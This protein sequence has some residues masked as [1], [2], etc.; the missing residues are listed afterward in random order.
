MHRCLIGFL[1][2][3]GV[4]GCQTEDPTNRDALRRTIDSVNTRIESWYAKGQVDSLVSVFA[5]DA[6]Q[7][8]PNR[9]PLVGRDSIRAFWAGAVRWGQWEF[10]FQTADVVAADSVAVE[11]GRYTLK[12]TAGAEAPLPSLQDRGNYV[13]YWRRERDG[14]WRIVWDAPVSVLPP[15][16]SAPRPRR[17]DPAR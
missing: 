6:W 9:A 14:Q 13:V 8:P 3:A 11:R 4:S 17:S 16:G 2:G 1:V 15:A 7:M 5:E 12:F 10:D